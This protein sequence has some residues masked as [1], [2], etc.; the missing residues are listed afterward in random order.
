[1]K[2]VPSSVLTLQAA[3]KLPLSVISCSIRLNSYPK[4]GV[5]STLEADAF[6]ATMSRFMC[7]SVLLS[8]EICKNV[9]AFSRSIP[10]TGALG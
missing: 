1:M 10:V 9:A 8:D 2:A 3:R 7:T 5:R 4:G 6:R